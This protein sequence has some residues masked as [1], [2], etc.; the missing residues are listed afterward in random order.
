MKALLKNKVFLN[1]F[2]FCMTFGI[3]YF[4][5]Q[6][7]SVKI[8]YPVARQ[9][10]AI[11]SLIIS[12]ML[13]LMKLG[14]SHGKKQEYKDIEYG[15]SHWGSTKKDLAKYID[16][17]FFKNMIFS[18]TEYLSMDQHKTHLDCHSLVIGATGAGKSRFYALLNIMQMNAS[19]VITDPNGGLLLNTGKMLEGHGYKVKVF[20][21][22]HMEN[23]LR[24]NPLHY[25][26]EPKD[27]MRFV[28][29]LI[30][31]TNGG[32]QKGVTD[33][34][35]W[36]NC[37]N[38]WFLAHIA[39]IQET[40]MEE[41]KNI[42]SLALLLENSATR[43]EDEDYKSAV[44]I[45]FDELE[46]QNPSSFAVKVYKKYKLGAGKSLKSILL[47]VSVRLTSFDIPEVS[48]LLSDDELDLE[49]MGDEKTALFII[50]SDTDQTYN[51]IVAILLDVLCNILAQNA[52]DSPGQH[53]KIPVRCILDE[54]ANIGYFPNLHTMVSVLRKRWI[55]LEMLFQNLGQLKALYKDQ[56]ETIATNCATT[57]F[58]GGNGEETTK[59]VSHDLLGKA[60]ID[61]V[62]YGGSGTSG[63]LGKNSYNSNE[64]KTGRYLLE[65]T[66]LAQLNSTDCITCIRGLPPFRGKKYLPQNHPNYKFLAEADPA[67]TYRFHRGID[68]KNADIQYVTLNLNI[69]E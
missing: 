20:D 13:I 52:D 41:E 31:N 9:T 67:N 44:D 53:L 60:T 32:V 50:V 34:N 43:E 29:L 21:V 62:S 57:L 47:S 45:L 3:M 51:F 26:R 66:E 2:L 18:Q 65:E 5:V 24:F 16:P 40:C 63:S 38:L 23:S 58:L 19:Y 39:Y 1:A 69:K 25:Y 46:K 22:E 49:K 8:Q 14:S 68:T 37:E 17:D 48:R 42:N 55:S 7:A 30:H 27:I 10:G 15:A 59:Y 4:L 36:D 11:I 61:T 12:S 28:K 35:F 54:I 64:Q 6:W 33:A 56:W